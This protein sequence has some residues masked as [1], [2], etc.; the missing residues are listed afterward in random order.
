[1][2]NHISYTFKIKNPG[3]Y[4]LKWMMRQPEG[5][6][7]T[8]K[9]NDVYIYLSDDLGYAKNKK[10]THYEKFYSRSGDDFVLHGVAEVHELGH[11][12]LTAKFPESGEFTLNIVGRSHGLQIDRIVLFKELDMEDVKSILHK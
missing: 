11:G 10:L 6:R 9:G 5:E 8:D 12:W 4:T 3:N 1:M 7:G 2:N